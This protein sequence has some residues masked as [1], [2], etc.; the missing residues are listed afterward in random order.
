VALFLSPI[1]KDCFNA[2]L[3]GAERRWVSLGDVTPLGLKLR[4]IQRARDDLIC[5]MWVQML[6]E[7][8]EASDCARLFTCGAPSSGSCLGTLP[9]ASL[10]L[11]LSDSEVGL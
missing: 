10:G 1:A 3:A 6:L 11:R 7:G 8:A 4:T 9:T 2:T 5:G